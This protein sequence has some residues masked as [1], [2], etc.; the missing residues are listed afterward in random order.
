MIGNGAHEYIVH[1]KKLWGEITVYSTNA[2]ELCITRK[3]YKDVE[4]T[5][6]KTT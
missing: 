1:T 2:R 5:M 4:M 3:M 6:P